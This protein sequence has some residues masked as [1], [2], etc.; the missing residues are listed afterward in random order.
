MST[1]LSTQSLTEKIEAKID[2]AVTGDL[3]VSSDQGG[4]QFKNASE[5]MEFAKIMAVSGVALPAHM[6]NNV[7]VCIAICV[8]AI[9]WRMSPFAVANKSYVVNDRV[10]YESQLI[11]AVIE[12]RAP[13]TKRLRHS[14]AGEGEQRTCT[15]VGY[16]RG[17]D[18]PFSY[19]SPP[20][21]K[22]QPKNSP[23][24][25]T[26]PDLQLFYNASRDWARMFFPDVIMGVYSDDEIA[27][28]HGTYVDTRPK[29]LA[30]LAKREVTQEAEVVPAGPLDE[31]RAALATA[32]TEDEARDAYEKFGNPATSKWTS[33][34][35]REAAT[36]LKT[37]IE[38]LSKGAK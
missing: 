32:A 24:W 31:Y 11:H 15:V 36:A 2:K 5:L 8:Q 33:D 13:L 9:E 16:V 37:R 6:R 29:N 23:L 1:A 34:D 17:E 30:D 28:S 4:M 26:K 7:G 14:F 18:E 19:T 3:S 35:D 25:K 21:G 10:S 12:Q 22:I 38:E 20:F 27:E